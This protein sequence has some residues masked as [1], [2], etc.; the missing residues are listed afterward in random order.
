VPLITIRIVIVTS[1]PFGSPI[2]LS[3]CLFSSL[4]I[5]GLLTSFHLFK[6][7]KRIQ[8]SVQ[9]RSS[10]ICKY[11]FSAL[12]SV[13]LEY[14]QRPVLRTPYYL[15]VYRSLTYQICTQEFLR[16]SDLKFFA[17][18]KKKKY[19]DMYRQNTYHCRTSVTGC[20]TVELQLLH[21]GTKYIER[22]RP[23]LPHLI[24]TGAHFESP[25][26][27]IRFHVIQNK[28]DGRR[29]TKYPLSHIPAI[30]TQ[31]PIWCINKNHGIPEVWMLKQ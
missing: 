27:A 16:F 19:K 13:R 17:K 10:K 9:P 21:S 4:K 11:I 6:Y 23:V 15:R 26:L 2:T 28:Y 14:F 5:G 31:A 25:F 30:T 20:L 12:L 1:P 18:N 29:K 8:R 24:W 3:I 22:W 7:P